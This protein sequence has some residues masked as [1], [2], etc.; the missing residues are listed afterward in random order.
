MAI[1]KDSRTLAKSV[2]KKE[3]SYSEEEKR[4]LS[5]R[6]TEETIDK[7]SS[8]VEK[9]KASGELPKKTTVSSYISWIMD[10]FA[11]EDIKSDGEL[12]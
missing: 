10:C 7:I 3:K 9:L 6:L 12:C 11:K 5:I 1:T 2:R 8:R 4:T